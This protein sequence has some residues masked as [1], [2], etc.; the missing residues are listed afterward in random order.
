V[1]VSVDFASGGRQQALLQIAQMGVNVLAVR[2]QQDRNVGGRA[3][4]GAIVQTLVEADY[5]GIRRQV[6]AIVRSS[7]FAT[8]ALR[9]KAGDLS[10]VAPVVGCEPS[11]LRIKNWQLAEGDF[12]DDAAERRAARVA[13][14]GATVA[15]DIFGQQS[16]IGRQ[17]SV[18]RTPFEVI[19][20]LAERGQGL[21]VAAE[22]D[23]IY[24][25]LR[26]AMLRLM[27]VDF[28][29]GL[30]LEVDQPASMDQAAASVTDLLRQR[31]RRVANLPDDFQVQNQQAL[32]ETQLASSERLG[33]YVRWIALSGLAVAGLGILAVC[34]I[35][36]KGRTVEIGTRRALGA[37]TADIF[38]QILL[39][40][41]F[42]S[43]LGSAAGL[44]IGWLGSQWLAQRSNLPFV[45]EWP[46][47]LLA[48]AVSATMNFLFSLLPAARAA[49]VSPMRALKY[50]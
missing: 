14:L 23:Q 40:A 25:P 12:F 11:F 39:E 8:A 22:D 35:A 19:G 41:A 13:V 24:V 27:N 18:N 42:L 6:P 10:K 28:Y 45:V 32:L 49:S 21:D 36:V 26:T 48:L 44:A 33:F 7:A 38:T 34:W 46:S 31:H 43:S 47:V 9:L 17:L 15:R 2:P 20:V 29:S 30:L 5:A 16:P 3:R 37:N 1:I 4:T 50:E